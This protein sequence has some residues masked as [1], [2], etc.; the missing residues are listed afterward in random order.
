VGRG[1]EGDAKGQTLPNDK[2]SLS[3]ITLKTTTPLPEKKKESKK[4][5]EQKQTQHLPFLY[6]K[7]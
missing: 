2:I 1:G 5:E 4:K 6:I 3:S 7:K